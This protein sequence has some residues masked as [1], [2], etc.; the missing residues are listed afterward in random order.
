[1]A[2]LTMETWRAAA[3]AERRA[4]AEAA[5]AGRALRVIRVDEL[6]ALIHHEPTGLAFHLVPGGTLR[7]GIG[8]DELARLRAQYQFWDGA[9]E[10]DH[11][12]TS[13]W[14]RPVIDVAIGTFLLAAHP[15]G[16]AVE[17]SYEA[18][19]AMSAEAWGAYLERFA[20]DGLALDDALDRERA[21][22]DQGL[23]L[24]S[25]AE[26]EWAARAG[27]ARSFPSGDAIP[28]SPNTGANPLGFVDLGALPELCA[29]AWAP[30]LEATPRDGAA[31]RGSEARVV[32]GGGATCYPWQDC[33]EWTLL[34]CGARGP[35]GEM[36]GMLAVRPA[37]GLS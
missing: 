4:L 2:T 29:D 8:D 15:I 35:V 17:R 7:M 19:A 3:P 32:R 6:V 12:L 13:G 18:L 10:A 20:A 25:E 26:W 14:S 11:A 23:R 30:T 21:L 28:E 36:D 34:L 27:S 33:G 22:I 16:P 24:P 37:M 5:C 1:M 9:N 31:R